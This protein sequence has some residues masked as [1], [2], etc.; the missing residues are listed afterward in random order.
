MSTWQRALQTSIGDL[1][2]LLNFLELKHKIQAQDLDPQASFRLKVPL[3]YLHKIQKGNPHDPLLKQILP[4]VQEQIATEAFSFDPLQEKEANPI[5]GLLHKY[6]GRV[7][8]TLTGTC[9]IHCRYCFRRHFP[10]EDNALSQTHWSAIWDYLHAHPEVIEV[11]F[12]GG[13][14]LVIKDSVLARYIQSLAEIPHLQY[15]RIHSRLFNLL[16]ERITPSLIEALTSTRLN[17]ILVSHIN[18]PREIDHELEQAMHQLRSAQIPVFNQSVLLRGVNDDLDILVELQKKLFSIHIQPYYLHRL[19]KVAGSAHFD[20]PIEQA[21][22]LVL[23]L[24]ARLPGYLV[25]K[26]VEER[27]KA[28][29]KIPVPLLY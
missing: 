22:A 14:P 3:K 12:S 27:P 5:P 26:F 19:D 20:L 6:L 29:A 13:D 16:P 25:P 7:L 9:A 17:P 11:I 28:P 4:L 24:A 23:A 8:L 18:H 15:L 10:Y 1:E 21:R 2:S